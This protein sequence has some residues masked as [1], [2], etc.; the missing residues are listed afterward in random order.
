MTEYRDKNQI[1]ILLLNPQS[2]SVMFVKQLRSLLLA[3][4][5][6]PMLASAQTLTYDTIPGDPLRARVYTLDNGLKV[7]LSVYEDEPRF[8]SMIAVKAGSKHDPADHTGLAHYLEHMLFKGT[9]VYGTQ[10]YAKEAPLL[11]TIFNLYERYGATSDSAQRA[12]IYHQ[13]DSVSGVAATYAIPNEFDKMMAGM[14][15][16]GVNAFTSNEQTVYINNVPSNQLEN[17]LTIEAERFRK[18]VMRLFH[19]ELEAVYEEKN[20]SLDS[21]GSKLWENLYGGLFPNHQ[22]GTQTTIGTI[23]HL[24]S[25][26]LKAIRN[27]F[28]TYYVPNNMVI[29]LSGDFDPDMAIKLINEKFG[30]MP[31]KPV[32]EFKVAQEKLI[33][34]PIVREVYGPDQES[35]SMAFRFKGASSEEADVLTI[36]DYI[37]SNGQAGLLDLNLNNKQKVLS[38]SSGTNIMRDYSIHILSGRPREGQTL[39]QVRDL[40]LGQIMEIKLGNFPD[41]IIPAI[42]TNMRLEQ[43]QQYENNM[44]RASAMLEGEIVGVNYKN[45]VERIDRLSRINKQQVIDFVRTWYGDNYVI[46]FK[47]NGVDENVVKVVK[48][49]ITPVAT[50]ADKQ[51]VFL[52]NILDSKPAEI[53]P[54]FIDFKTRIKEGALKNGVPVYMVQNTENDMFSMEFNWEMGYA[55]NKN[56]SVLSQYINFLG[57]DKYSSSQLQE[58]FYKLGCSFSASVAEDEMNISLSGLNIN[59]QKAMDLLQQVLNAPKADQASLTNLVND[60]L[61]RRANAKL[62]KNEILSRV[63]SYAKFGAVSPSTYLLSEQELKALKGEDLTALLKSLPAYKHKIDYYGPSDSAM[64]IS[65]L[66]KSHKI[67]RSLKDPLPAQQFKEESTDD[68]KV[69]FVNYEMKQAEVNFLSKGGAYDRNL[70]PIV[71]LYSRY[72]GGG[73]SSPVFQ[74]L[75]ES[76]AL[77]YAVSSRYSAPSRPDRSYYNTA[78]IGTQADKLPEAMAG[79]MELLQ[80]MPAAQKTFENAKE[81]ALQGIATDRITKDEVL[82]LYHSL[83]RMGVN[84][85]LRKDMYEGI[86]KMTL[87]DVVAFQKKMVKDKKYRIAMIGNREKVDFKVLEKYGQVVELDLQQVF[88]Y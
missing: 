82:R 50:N 43:Q 83:K 44:R 46:V 10:D 30:K 71:S 60:V 55:N 24:K 31:T 38:S 28:E 85:D 79:M 21:D 59:F 14:G 39:E 81:G 22:Y 61:K 12:K 52:K 35:M 8:Q 26:S 86:S 66:N 54:E 68:S 62:N 41:W 57:T 64:V 13:I 48:P 45:Q 75:R 74:T 65:G 40:I 6:L 32:P 11:D 33:K 27:Y 36:V 63:S 2:N 18:P 34:V 37:L 29:A 73:M 84:Y 87:E 72:F 58:E 4:M 77:A 1:E 5:V 15:V 7:Y 19:T 3:L 88:G 70:Q 67:I 49:E 47:R 17:F 25:P 78:Y 16:T 20:R 80:D 51:T 42:I 9:D 56:L 76:K 23:E 69:F 53:A